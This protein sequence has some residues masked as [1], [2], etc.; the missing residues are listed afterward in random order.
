MLA[1]SEKIWRLRSWAIA[2]ASTVYLALVGAN[3]Y[4][5][6][7]PDHNPQL[8]SCIVLL[9]GAMGNFGLWHLS[10]V[11][12][13][14]AIRLAC[15]LWW[16]EDKHQMHQGLEQW[17]FYSELAVPKRGREIRCLASDVQV[18]LAVSYAASLFIWLWISR[19]N[20]LFLIFFVSSLI[21][22]CIG[23]CRRAA[24]YRFRAKAL[25][26][27]LNGANY[28]AD[29]HRLVIEIVRPPPNPK[30]GGEPS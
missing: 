25:R 22:L 11:R 13:R 20:R 12:D 2:L 10:I 27:F 15:F 30:A 23:A 5:K 26:E 17:A 4:D 3:F 1:V 21:L 19:W 6:V 8:F 9:V 7:A 16:F 29:W 18:W 14:S 28:A 24:G